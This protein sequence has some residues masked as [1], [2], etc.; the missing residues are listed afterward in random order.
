[1]LAPMSPCTVAARRLILTCTAAW[2][3][4]AVMLTAQVPASAPRPVEPFS[5]EFLALGSDGAPLPDLTPEQV[6]LKLDGKARTLRTLEWVPIFD[7][8]TADGKRL[9][10]MPPPFATNLSHDGTRTILFV[11]DDYSFRPGRERPIRE[12]VRKFLGT[13]APRDKVTL[14]TVPYGGLKMDFTTE[15]ERID[16][17]LSKLVGQAPA[18][19]TGSEL[20]CRTRRS[21]ESLTG[22]LESM[23][24][25][26]G[27][28]TVLFFSSRLAG[29]RRDAVLSRAPGSCEITVD[30]FNRV[31]DAASAVRALFYII[32]PDD[33][34]LHGGSNQT[35]G[36]FGGGFIGSDN[37]LEGLEHLSGVTGGTRLQLQTPDDVSLARVS[38]ETGG[39]YIV[40]FEADPSDREGL[41]REV[42]L[43]VARPG[44][45]LRVRPLFTVPRPEPPNAPPTPLSMLRSGRVFRGLPLRVAGFVSQNAGDDKLKVV[46]VVEPLDGTARIASLAAAL[47]D[48]DE[49]AVAQWNASDTDARPLV[50]ALAAPPGLYRLRV[51]ATD[52]NGRAGTAD[53]EVRAELA[54]A[55]VL[56]LSGVVLGVSKNGA[57]SPRLDFTREPSA[58]ASVEVYGQPGSEP[59]WVSFE[60]AT[61]LN[62]PALVTTP[63]VIES[64][65]TRDRF[66]ATGAVPIDTLPPGDYVVRAVGGLKG[67]PTGRV[68][69]TLRKLPTPN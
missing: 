43:R 28:T 56:S 66:I 48:S 38:R 44:A 9:L 59:M 20:A 11:L 29:P 18:T 6:Q 12:V 16:I 2:C 31:G 53:Y 26:E 3:A 5:L 69:R 24:G 55:G 19:E 10:P 39:Y 47:F 41:R 35:E 40:R 46:T 65:R 33:T 54:P 25:G 58:I 50:G 42:G 60:L 21:L 49:R 62:G 57:F 7:P 8:R 51:A 22:L 37:P 32:Q 45:T 64:T 67:Q 30:H 36:L 52:V 15:H 14:V 4:A 63:G 34:M 68:L 23:R 27:P 61:T 17:E 13:L 1:M